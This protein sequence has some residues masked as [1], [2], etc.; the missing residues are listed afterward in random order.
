[1]R[2]TP[3]QRVH[4]PVKAL[5]IRSLAL[6]R[7][8]YL[9]KNGPIQQWSLRPL[10]M[11]AFAGAVSGCNAAPR[12]MLPSEQ[13]VQAVLKH[14]T[15]GGDVCIDDRTHGDALLVFREMTG[16]PKPS[17][18]ELHWSSPEPLRPNQRVATD[19]IK[20]AE[21]ENKQLHLAEPDIRTAKLDA[22]SQ[23]QLTGAARVLSRGIGVERESVRIRDSWTPIGVA[24]RWWPI[25]RVRMD[26]WPRYEISDP[27]RL[28]G[29][30][31]VSVKAGHWGTLYALQRRNQEW[32]VIA[33]WSRWLY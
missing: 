3:L 27:A 28:K 2:L 14:L 24:A 30:A 4:S 10:L 1:M 20:E 31:F 22:L 13:I 29:T 9:M 6:A 8:V 25:N 32:Q 7:T 16:A 23:R 26:C 5:S 18:D 17:R 15:T 33:E 11:M 19:A 12:P 21:L